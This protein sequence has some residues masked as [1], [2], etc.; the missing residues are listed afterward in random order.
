MID[1]LILWGRKK[2]SKRK[3][4]R[5]VEIRGSKIREKSIGKPVDELE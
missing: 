2:K 1:T 4:G 5:E 3:K